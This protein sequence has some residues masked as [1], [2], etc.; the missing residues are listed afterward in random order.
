MIE[1]R[2]EEERRVWATLAMGQA[3]SP[4]EA[5]HWADELLKRWRE[6]ADPGKEREAELRGASHFT[7]RVCHECGQ[8]TR[9]GPECSQCGAGL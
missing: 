1:L 2:D 8:M 9:R 6:R 7:H 4:G 5:A 3:S